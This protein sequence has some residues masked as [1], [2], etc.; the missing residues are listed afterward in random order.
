MYILPGR[1]ISFCPAVSIIMHINGLV[2]YIPIIYHI[3]LYPRPISSLPVSLPE[4]GREGGQVAREE[5]VGGGGGERRAGGRGRRE[6]GT[7]G[8]G[9]RK[10]YL[11]VELIKCRPPIDPNEGEALKRGREGG[12]EGGRREG[13]REG[14]GIVHG[15]KEIL[16]EGGIDQMY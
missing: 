11:R 12:G 10:F 16:P 9:R 2:A 15:Q 1:P 7:G 3:G 13:G 5:G 14:W 4:G 8:W 6:G